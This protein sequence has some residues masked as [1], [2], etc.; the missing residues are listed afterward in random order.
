MNTKKAP[1][2]GTEHF[3]YEPL[4][5]AI[6]KAQPTTHKNG[7]QQIGLSHTHWLRVRSGKLE[8][9]GTQTHSKFMRWVAANKH[10]LTNSKDQQTLKEFHDKFGEQ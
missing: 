8:G 2:S 3:N 5:L 7:C 1:Y 10:L 9:M 4:F 6:I